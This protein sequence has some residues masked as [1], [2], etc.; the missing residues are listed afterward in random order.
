MHVSFD[1]CNT[2]F[3]SNPAFKFHRLQMFKDRTGTSEDLIEHTFAAV[4]DWHNN[5]LMLKDGLALTSQSLCSLAFRILRVSPEDYASLIADMEE[6]FL[7]YPPLPTCNS[8]VMEWRS[9][10]GSASILSN[11]TFISGAVIRSF[12]DSEQEEFDFMIFSDELGYGKPQAKAFQAILFELRSRVGLADDQQ[13]F[14]VGDDPKFDSSPTG[15][16]KSILL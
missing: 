4:G 3:T 1:F 10:A 6:L 11:T 15:D 13:I 5:Q 9:C 14:H 2:L 8:T 7:K 16:I 12:L